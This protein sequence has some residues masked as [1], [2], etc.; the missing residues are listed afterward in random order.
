MKRETNHKLNFAS[1]NSLIR[2]VKEKKQPIGITHKQENL[3]FTHPKKKS[4]EEIIR[5]E[6]AAW[7]QRLLDSS[8]QSPDET[9][10]SP[11]YEPCSPATPIYDPCAPPLSN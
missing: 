11:N 6:V 8:Q 9:P 7:V 10:S 1:R 4:R 3:K 2:R 5:E